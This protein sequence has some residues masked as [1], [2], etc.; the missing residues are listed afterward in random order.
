MTELSR[1][2]RRDDVSGKDRPGGLVLVV[3]DDSVTRT[4]LTHV[5]QQAGYAVMTVEDGPSALDVL[6]HQVVDLVLLD[7]RMPV[8]DGY[9]VCRQ[10]RSHPDTET[11]PV[12]MITAEGPDEKISAFDVGADD[13]ILKPVER[14]ELLAR[15]R[16]LLHIKDVTILQRILLGT[17]GTFTHI[18]EA[19]TGEPIRV[20]K[21]DE[22]VEQAK[23]FHPELGDIDTETTLRR[24]V[25][26]RGGRTD[27]ALIHADALVLLDRLP[28]GMGRELVSTRRPIG[29]LLVEHRVETF[30]EIVHSGY[31]A[32]G[33]R[34]GWFGIDETDELLFRTS[35]VFS[36]GRSIMLVTERF[37]TTAF[38][39]RGAISEQ[40]VTEP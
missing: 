39:M 32:A 35:R 22:V 12:M 40:V 29:K 24:T 27:T 13:F 37:P 7:I 11:L 16:S 20:V 3:D 8:M 26:L 17:N 31:E 30:R 4:L 15:V 28:H 6:A 33:G 2:A 25:L 19:C 9:E 23:G 5:L 34:A 36:G 1:K 21:L 10:I 18:I 38:R 14:N